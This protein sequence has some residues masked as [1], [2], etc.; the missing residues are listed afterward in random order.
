MTSADSLNKIFFDHKITLFGVASFLEC[1]A[2]DCRNS[3]KIPHQAKSVICCAFP[4]L[5]KTS[6]PRNLCYYACVKDYHLVVGGI[7]AEI[8]QNLA[9]TFPHK[10]VPFVDN[11]PIDEVPAAVLAGIGVR[12]DNSLLITKEFGSYVFLGEIVTDMEIMPS[13]PSDGGCLH[14]SAC[15]KACP[16]SC[17]DKKFVKADCLS[18][19]S[20]KKGILSAA[21]EDLLRK[22]GLAWGCDACQTACPMNFQAKET[23]IAEF[24]LSAKH[25]ITAADVPTEIP[26]AAYGWRGE[27]VIRRNLEL[28]EKK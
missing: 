21:E 9:K 15:K 25:F 24:L 1:K 28:L 11:S 8:C 26:T 12:G 16:T 19:I 22:N 18:D 4:Y 3:S 2:I 17:L 20:Q 6:Q 13:I 14:C 27:K 23:Q 7:L 5:V 10:F